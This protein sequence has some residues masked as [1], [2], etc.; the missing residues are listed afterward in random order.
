MRAANCLKGL[1]IV[2]VVLSTGIAALA[3]SGIVINEVAWAGTAAQS[4]DEW[5]ELYN[6]S[7][8]RVDLAGWTL[9]FG[10]TVIHLGHADGSTLE[11][12]R[13]VIEP[14]GFLVLE[15]TDD[16]TIS[17]IVADV[18]YKG[19]LTNQGMILRLLDPT[20]ATFDTANLLGNPWPAGN[21]ADGNPSYASM[22]RILP[23]DGDD[24]ANWKT[25]D[26]SIRCGGDANGEPINGT[27]GMMNSATLIAQTFPHVVL[28]APQEGKTLKGIIEVAWL[29]TDPDGSP[30]GL[31]VDISLARDGGE[32]WEPIAKGLAN[33]GSYRWDTTVYPDGETYRLRIT[34]TDFE[35]HMG[36]V[37]SP[38]LLI[39][40]AT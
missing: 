38:M 33:G 11:V 14:M 1:G 21:S 34:V 20:G 19:N 6:P 36:V 9:T 27:P 17:D 25:N 12:R 32:T 7:D 2:V 23:T 3:H 8:E 26:G 35:G 24:P 40:N 30:E 31:Q 16:T 18:I 28:L 39:A 29:A 22:E 15:R 4:V 5:I 10:D 37:T 13:S